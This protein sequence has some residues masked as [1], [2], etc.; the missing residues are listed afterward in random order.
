MWSQPRSTIRAIVHNKPAFGVFYLAAIYALQ[1]FFFYANW[2]SLGLKTNYYALI[3]L[4]VVLSPFIGALWLYFM[5]WVFSL[6]GRFL[7]GRAPPS[8]LRSAIAWSKLP[9]SISLLMWLIL[10]FFTPEYVFIQG[11]SGFSSIFVNFI[12]LILGIWSLVLLIQGVR[13]VQHFS[14][15]RS[16]LNVFLAWLL[17][18]AILLLAF[19]LM[20]YLYIYRS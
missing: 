13:E 20:R 1:S 17:S 12:T 3:I 10:I 4:G 8:H 19:V 15:A 9:T 2:W 11:A 14:L 7:K 5:G 6:S 18:T 16:I